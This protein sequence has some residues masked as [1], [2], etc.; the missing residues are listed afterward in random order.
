[1][2]TGMLNDEKKVIDMLNQYKRKQAESY[3]ILIPILDGGGSTIGFL[4]PITADFRTTMADCVE[5]LDQWRIENP[6]MSPSRFPITHE[7]TERWII[8]SI[9]NNDKRILFL[10]QS[11][12]NRYIGHMGFTNICPEQCSAEIDLV[13]KGQKDTPYGFM[14]CAMNAMVQW[15]KRELRLEHIAVVVLWDNACGI[16]YYKRCGFNE[17]ELIPLKRVEAQDEITWVPCE[18][19]PDRA[20]KYYLHMRLC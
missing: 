14:T 11:L 7:R 10:I 13:V 2:N 18:S 9:I 16:S 15:G 6:C 1:M 12:A 3:L 17:E 19:T 20:E 8:D 4:R 5:L